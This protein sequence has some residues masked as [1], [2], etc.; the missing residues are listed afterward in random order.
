MSAAGH[1]MRDYGSSVVAISNYSCLS[2]RLIVNAIESSPTSVSSPFVIADYGCADGSQNMHVFS[3]II[4]LARHKYG[5]DLPILV[6]HEDQQG[7]DFN[8][9]FQWVLEKNST[10]SY[11]NQHSNIFTI[12]S[13]TGFYSQCLP[14]N[15]VDFGFSSIAVHW[16]SKIPTQI[17]GDV[18]HQLKKATP[19]EISAFK[20]QAAIDWDCFLLHRAKELKP[21]G[22]LVITAVSHIDTLEA[23]HVTNMSDIWKSFVDQNIITEEEFQATNFPI[24]WRTVD[25]FKAPFEDPQSSVVKAGLRLVSITDVS[26]ISKVDLELDKLTTDEL[27]AF[28]I[29]AAQSTSAWSYT[30]FYN[31]LNTNRPAEQRQEIVD[32]LYARLADSMAQRV[33]LNRYNFPAL[34]MHIE[35]R[36]T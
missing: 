11:S 3:N 13:A 33:N 9:L 1:V 29:K 2:A 20:R 5:G 6:C 26:V 12:A 32:N 34:A 27:K 17:R 16:L 22:Q 14:A 36:V 30:T 35:K 23:S 7:N 31:G 8:S 28:G 19:E 21:G 15:F 10:N 24:R 18:F 4:K 25:E